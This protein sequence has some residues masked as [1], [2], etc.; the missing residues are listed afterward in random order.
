M[1][2]RSQRCWDRTIGSLSSHCSPSIS[3]HCTSR[4]GHFL[5]SIMQSF[6]YWKHVGRWILWVHVTYM[7]PLYLNQSVYRVLINALIWTDISRSLKEEEHIGQYFCY[8]WSSN[9]CTRKCKRKSWA[10]VRRKR[11]LEDVG[12]GHL[13]LKYEFSL[14]KREIAFISSPSFL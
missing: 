2:Y 5:A 13:N 8:G 1:R 14:S 12:K 11:F 3:S 9:S 4:P 6:Y 10:L 7:K